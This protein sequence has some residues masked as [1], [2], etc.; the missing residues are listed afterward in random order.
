MRN[1]MANTTVKAVVAGV[2]IVLAG[3][4]WLYLDCLNKQEATQSAQMQ[5]EMLKMRAEGKQRLDAAKEIADAKLSVENQIRANLASCQAAAEKS[6]KDY[7]GVIEKTL[8]RKRGQVVMPPIIVSESNQIL[9]S[10]NAECQ[11]NHDALIQKV[12]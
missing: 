7:L 1:L 6:H 12:Q 8:P 9:A 2:L 4:G 11:Q 10:A 5:Q 3:G